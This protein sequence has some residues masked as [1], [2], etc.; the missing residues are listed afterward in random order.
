MARIGQYPPVGG[1]TD[2]TLEFR[3]P[4]ALSAV[5]VLPC[6]TLL[7]H[8]DISRVGETCIL[9]QRT[10]LS[11]LSPLFAQLSGGASR[12]LDDPF[13]SRQ[14]AVLRIEGNVVVIEPSRGL[15]FEGEPLEM[16]I[17]VPRPD[18]LRGVVLCL[19][20]RVT[21]LLHMAPMRRESADA[22]DLGLVGASP[23][24]ERVRQDIRR[25]ADVDVPVLVRG[26]SG[27]GKELVAHAVHRLS[28]RSGGPLVVLNMGAVPSTLAASELFGHEKGAFSGADRRREGAFGQ[29]D[30]GT[31]FL[32]EVGDTPSDV[33]PLLLRALENGEIQP[34]GAARTRRV[35][36]R[37]VAAT[38][39]DLEAG[40]SDGRF[41]LP[42]L[43]RLAGFQLQIPPLR[44][45]REDIGRL[46]YAFLRGELEALG[47]AWRLTVSADGMAF[48][49]A[50][51]V[52]RLAMYDWPGN[53]RQL[54]NV[55]RQLAIAARGAPQIP[56]EAHIDHLLPGPA[57]R[58]MAV[59][60]TATQPAARPVS[61]YR[62]PDE[63]RE[64]ELL[65]ALRAHGWRLAPTAKALGVSRTTLYA[66]VEQSKRI[67]KAADLGAP[68][69][70]AALRRNGGRIAPAAEE[71]EVSAHALKIR[72]SALGLKG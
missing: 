46:F 22:D 71:L 26:E 33:Q 51:L 54:R 25:V 6:L 12:P 35:D 28:E 64:D 38:D 11:R 52:V 47:E 23:G 67:R 7:S 9:Q 1:P 68:E 63:V 40:V 3:A 24:I 56:W 61:A 49:P 4:A 21:L 31:L 13:V 72:M 19:R 70:E 20:E 8:P 29:A 55:A 39:A 30:G 37:L 2:S 34:V 41:R 53:V 14:P 48:V 43:Q 16:S 57:T 59:A 27:V 17:A 50:P 44:E 32:D 60:P 42:L 5:P 62:D 36:V 58:E 10:E 69:I 66:L 65:A 45:R 18:L 15:T